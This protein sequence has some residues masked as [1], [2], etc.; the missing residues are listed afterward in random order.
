M[1]STSSQL[2]MLRTFKFTLSRYNLETIYF[3]YILPLLE[4]ACELWDGCTQQEYNKIDQIQHEAARLITGLPKLSSLESLYF[5]TS[6]SSKK[7]KIKCFTKFEITMHL[8]IYATVYYPL[9]ETK[10]LTICVIKQIIVT[11]LLGYWSVVR[12][13]K[14]VIAFNGL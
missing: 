6:L 12:Y 3:T 2:S 13:N 10:M 1:E 5:E 9:S 14:T 7:K 4:Y 8:R 11:H